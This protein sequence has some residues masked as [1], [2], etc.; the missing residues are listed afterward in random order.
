MSAPTQGGKAQQPGK[1]SGYVQTPQGGLNVGGMTNMSG[2]GLWNGGGGGQMMPGQMMQMQNRMGGTGYTPW[3]GQ[4]GDWRQDRM[5]IQNH[6]RQQAFDQAMNQASGSLERQMIQRKMDQMPG[7]SDPNMGVL[8][9]G[10]GQTGGG[11]ATLNQTGMA[12]SGGKGMGG[13]K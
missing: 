2:G 4:R 10:P 5:N 11:M 13:G 8:G 3:S 9:S 12:P 7:I 6:E 1:Q